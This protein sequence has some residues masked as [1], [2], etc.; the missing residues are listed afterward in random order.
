MEEIVLQ[1]KTRNVTGKQVKALRREG[2]LPAV[3]YGRAKDSINISLDFR[4]SSRV[5][6]T[7][8]SSQL[9]VVDVDG[10][11]HTTLVRDRQRQ[12][13]TGDLLHVDFLE[14]SMTEKLRTR[15]MIELVGESPAVKNVSGILVSNL[16]ELHVE[17]Y[18]GDLPERI[19]VD[20]SKLNGVGKAIYVRDIQAIKG[21][22]ILDE[23]DELIVVITAQAAEEELEEAE[24]EV[25]EEPEIIERGKKEEEQEEEI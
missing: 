6:P 23:D 14:V 13:V 15:V 2:V 3:I 16:E 11:K 25:G 20:I 21:V 5:I 8:T 22:E 17:A 10:K 24:E 18:P 4:E 19:T 1:A 9:V 7:I 12:P